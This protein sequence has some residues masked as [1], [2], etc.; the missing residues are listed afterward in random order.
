[1]VKQTDKNDDAL[2]QDEQK[3]LKVFRDFCDKIALAPRGS[4]TLT[5]TA[6]HGKISGQD[7]RVGG[8]W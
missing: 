2:N 7:I 4:V 3:M 5:I 1:M 8:E 6:R